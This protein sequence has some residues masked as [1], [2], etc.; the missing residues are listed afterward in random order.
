MEAGV[1]IPEDGKLF[2]FTTG[3]TSHLTELF[4]LHFRT[5]QSE[6]IFFENE[7]ALDILRI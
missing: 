4:A 7:E 6:F 2:K 5:T 1:D 3:R